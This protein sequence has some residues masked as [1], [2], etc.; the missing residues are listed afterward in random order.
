VKGVLRLSEIIMDDYPFCHKGTYAVWDES[1]IKRSSEEDMAWA[2]LFNLLE[3]KI[4]LQDLVFDCQSQLPPSLLDM[5][6]ERHPRCRL[7]HL[8]FNF[9]TLLCG[10]PDPY[11]M[12]LAISPSLYKVE[13]A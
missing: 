8:T 5:L 9:Q 3:A 7:H 13:V 6:H 4:P 11:E 10:V 2:P 12:E 1:V